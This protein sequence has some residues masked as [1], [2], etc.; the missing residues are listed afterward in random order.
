MYKKEDLLKQLAVIGVDPQGILKVHLS[1]KE[2]G[3]VDGRAD[4]VIAA[5]MEYMKDGLLVLASHT[6]G[7]MRPENPIM[8]V[9]YTKSCVGIV[10]ELFRHYPNV[11]RS[12]HPTHAVAVAGIGAAEF[13]AGDE[14][15]NTPAGIGGS[16]W[17]LWERDAQILLI[18]VNFNRNTFIHGI[19]EWDGA[20]GTIAE[21]LTDCYVINHDGNRIHAPLHLHTARNGSETFSKLEPQAAAEGILTF[22]KFGD[23]TTRLMSARKL[24]TMVAPILAEDPE[25]LLRY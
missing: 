2:I 21:K 23:A 20:I 14:L 15:I 16:Y 4:T 1:Y 19:E 22:G 18:G 25:Y 7:T 13:V 10:T 8:D 5:L 6:W 9:L 17:K 12:L 11:H 3:D 24:R